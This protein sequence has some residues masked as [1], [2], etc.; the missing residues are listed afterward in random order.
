MSMPMW[1]CALC[2]RIQ[3]VN[4]YARGFPPDAA[5]RKLVKA[6]ASNGCPCEPTY[7]AGIA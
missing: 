6:C 3:V 7:R 4:I 1:R 5:K 2:H